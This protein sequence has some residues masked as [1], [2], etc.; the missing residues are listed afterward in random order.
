VDALCLG[1]SMVVGCMTA[2]SE[3][4]GLDNWTIGMMPVVIESGSPFVHLVKM[5]TSGV[6]VT[7]TIVVFLSWCLWFLLPAIAGIAVVMA[8]IMA[9]AI[10][11]LI[12]FISL[13]PIL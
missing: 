6:L 7:T 10:T 12:I 4:A 11:L 3:R 13:S 1:Y 9:A 8:I 5:R 2:D